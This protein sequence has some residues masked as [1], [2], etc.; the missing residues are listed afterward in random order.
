M[1]AVF[2]KYLVFMAAAFLLFLGVRYWDGL[3]DFLGLALHAAMP[4]IIGCVIAYAVNILMSFY[5]EKLFA[6][7]ERK[8]L[9]KGK[10]PFCMILAFVSLVAIIVLVLI[11]VIP[12]L[13][14]CIKYLIEAVPKGVFSFLDTLEE[15]DLL[16]Q[17]VQE[18]E[19]F[20]VKNQKGFETQLGDGVESFFAGVGNVMSSVF[21]AISAVLSKLITLLIAFIFSIYLLA[22]KER[23]GKQFH[24]LLE[25]Y[26]PKYCEKINYVIGTFD[27]CFHHFIVGQCVEAVILGSLCSLGM[28]ILRLPYALMIGTFI[29][30]TALIPVAGAYIGGAVGVFMILTESPVKAVVFLIFLCLLQQVEGNVIY[31]RVVGNSIGL[32]GMWVLAAVTVGGSLL[33]IFGI[34]AAVPF[35]ASLYHL[36]Q[37]DVRKRNQKPAAVPETAE[38]EKGLLAKENTQ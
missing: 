38:N 19:D 12:E 23:L 3:I 25:T 10:R 9:Q 26:L 13:A 6:K 28:T 2:K 11:L 24:R 31:P 7:T 16:R 27:E 34:L 15:N 17:H 36:L 18:L 29:G 4:L 1:K 35:T 33:G 30:F 8:W 32:P 20:L 14:S 22:G 21:T 5:E 37:K